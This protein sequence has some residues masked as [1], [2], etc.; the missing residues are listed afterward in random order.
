SRQPGVPLS[1]SLSRPTPYFVTAL[2]RQVTHLCCRSGTFCV[3]VGSY[4]SCSAMMAAWSHFARDAAYLVRRFPT[5]T[6]CLRVRLSGG[7]KPPCENGGLGSGVGG[8]AR[9]AKK[10]QETMGT[11]PER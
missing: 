7:T 5:Q 8:D 1:S 11:S 9:R 3:F 2:P 4:A 10:A 6:P